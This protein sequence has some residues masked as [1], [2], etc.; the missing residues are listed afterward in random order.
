[1]TKIVN[2]FRKNV[3]SVEGLI[4]F[5]NEV[6]S[7]AIKIIEELHHSLLNLKEPIT[8][9]QLNGKRALEILSNIR[10]NESLKSKYSII[11]NQ[12][13]ILL[14]SYF[15]SAVA[16]LFR[17]AAK[18]AVV[19]HKDERVLNSEFKI[20]VSELIVIEE[21]LGDSIGD[22]LIVKNGISFQDMK[23][24]QRY[25]DKYFGI[26]IKK[27]ITVNNIILSQACR[28]AIAHEAS[29]VNSRILN[30]TKAANPREIKQSLVLGETIE[31]N[32]E[33]L[34][35]VSSSMLT[36]VENLYDK[37]STYCTKI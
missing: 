21:S 28:H 11:N 15:S 30:Q 27:D 33:E 1:M 29:I 20:K 12:A 18:A 4:S 5:D 34:K 16:D 6:I 10:T 3:E 8:N 17:E 9:D 2:T 23:S 32:E 35:L 36:Y 31:F 37:V 13:V 7:L 22:T 25:F 24:I 26:V 14:V 19:L